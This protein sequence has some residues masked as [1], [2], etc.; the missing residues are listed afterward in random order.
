MKQFSVAR[1]QYSLFSLSEVTC[2]SQKSWPK[3]AF[4]ALAL[5]TSLTCGAFAEPAPAP[6]TVVPKPIPQP[7]PS[8]STPVD[9]DL[10]V[11]RPVGN[12]ML[13][14]ADQI[15][16]LNSLATLDMSVW[17]SLLKRNHA[18]LNSE[19]VQVMAN[20][21]QDAMRKAVT[22][23]DALVKAQA[24]FERATA[25]GDRDQATAAADERQRAEKARNGY[26]EI[27]FR[28]ALLAD[29]C[30]RELH[31]PDVHRLQLAQAYAHM[32][33]GAPMALAVVGNILITDPN[34][35][36][37]RLLS[38]RIREANGDMYGAMVD[39]QF[40][41][42][43][44][45]NNATAWTAIGK[46]QLLVNDFVK[47]KDALRKA[48]ACTAGG[49]TDEAQKLLY[50]LEHPQQLPPPSDPS[51]LP[52]GLPSTAETAESIAQAA[53]KALR[54]NQV[55]EARK[56]FNRAISLEATNARAH[57]G[58]GDIYFRTSD[59]MKAIDEYNLA[60]KYSPSSP[61]PLRYMGLACEKVYDT[62]KSPIYLDRAIEC[63]AS[64]I[65]LKGDYAEARADQERLLGKKGN[66]PT[67]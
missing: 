49:S 31:Q 30:A 66:E 55:E 34:N 37:A 63:V 7:M 10:T 9:N 40:V 25:S 24:R 35:V 23:Y 17:P 5:G 65:R 60:A 13:K 45:A 38:G 39:F 43:K 61:I 67:H 46:A 27:S 15:N 50:S 26:V 6:P 2:L 48:V 47:A 64:A 19:F 14:N 52:G 20:R 1:R 36:Q 22:S 44:D 62:T 32:K 41:V 8:T 18:I 42:K 16:L 53:E 12:L 11:D 33:D 3:H 21:S 51:M 28:Y 56:G 57:M 29:L 58:L 4:L 59:F 54:E